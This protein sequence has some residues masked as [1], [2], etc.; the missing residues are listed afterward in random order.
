MKRKITLVM[1]FACL[2]ANAQNITDVLR[3]STENIQGTAR[4]QGLSGA[5]GALGGDL[6]AL[7][8]NPAGSAVFN[9]GQFSVSASNY[10]R[11]NRAKY[12]NSTSFSDANSLDINQ[13]GVVFVFDNTSPNADWK[14][15][16]LA[17]NYDVVQNYDDNIAISGTSNQGIDNYFLNF[18]QGVPFGPL[19]IQNGEF[20]EE[21]YLDIGSSLGFVDQQAFLG[22]YGGVIDPVDPDDNDNT[23]YISNAQ[24]STVNQQYFKS[25]SGYNSK[26]TVNMATQY[27]DNLYMGAS[28]NFHSVSYN[29]L[30]T[31]RETGYDSDSEIQFTTFDNLLRT[32][33]TGF[34]LTLGGIAKLNDNLRIGGSYQ[35]PTWYRLTDDT[36][37]RINSDLA[38]ADIGFINFNIV[39]LFE[40][41][42]IKTPAKVTGSMAIIFGKNG[43]LSLDYG[44]QDMSQAELRPTNDPAF[45]SENAFIANELGGVSTLRLGGE[46]RLDQ[47]SLRAGYRYEQSPYKNGFT[48]GDLNGYSAGIGYNFGGSR[49]DLA[50]N[51]SEQDMDQQLYSTG[52]VTPASINNRNTNITL[53][54]TLNF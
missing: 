13:L 20:I 18:A 51:K 47:V 19:L 49:L 32:E 48:V 4:F 46:Y 2:V 9:N 10:Y 30:T 35:S 8:V 52:L 50:Y 14:K 43:L 36:A 17:L 15:V 16:S 29:Q 21:A 26:F 25:T 24:Y 12:F 53:G 5:F 37:Q 34:S 31:L 28:L 23:S 54:Y 38:D 39:N 27:Q 33:G 42:N 41:Y 11:D 3:Y 45:Q 40:R 44:Y 1:V 7:N 22:Y 6:S